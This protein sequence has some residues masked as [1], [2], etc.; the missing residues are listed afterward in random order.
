[1]NP[2][3][4]ESL[5]RYQA[6]DSGR[7]SRQRSLKAQLSRRWVGYLERRSK[8]RSVT[9]LRG[10]SARASRR[11]PPLEPSAVSKPD[12]S[13]MPVPAAHF[14]TA[15]F[16]GE[17]LRFCTREDAARWIESRTVTGATL[18]RLEPGLLESPAGHAA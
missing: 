9:P 7:D 15:T 10:K 2:S 4:L 14:W 13:R 6:R 12:I 16:E 11:R 5:A 8:A 3:L 1:M 17:E 18:V